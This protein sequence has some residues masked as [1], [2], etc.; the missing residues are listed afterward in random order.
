MLNEH[1]SSSSCMH[2]CMGARPWGQGNRPSTYTV[3]GLT[4]VHCMQLLLE[5]LVS[6]FHPSI[7]HACL[8]LS[9]VPSP[10]DSIPSDP[11]GGPVR[12][13]ARGRRRAQAQQRPVV[14]AWRHMRWRIA[15]SEAEDRPAITA[16]WWSVQSRSSRCALLMRGGRVTCVWDHRAVASA[17]L[18]TPARRCGRAGGA[19]VPRVVRTLAWRAR[20]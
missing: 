1:S 10:A 16:C 5:Q 14:H 3:R 18:H 11:M 17:R 20:H 9:M 4:R 13:A 12:H 19:Y 6:A 8:S 15:G 7:D 2:A